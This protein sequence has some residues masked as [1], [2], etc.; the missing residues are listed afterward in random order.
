M[1]KGTNC[2][3]VLENKTIKLKHGYIAVKCR[4]QQDIETKKTI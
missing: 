3:N 4:S 1:D 2:L